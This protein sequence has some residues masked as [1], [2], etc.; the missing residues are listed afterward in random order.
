[1]TQRPRQGSLWRRTG[2]AFWL[3]VFGVLW[4]V[5]E[6]LATSLLPVDLTLLAAGLVGAFIGSSPLMLIPSTAR[7]AF[8]PQSPIGQP[9]RWQGQL[10]LL[11]V[12]ALMTAIA[13]ARVWPHHGWTGRGITE[14]G[15]LAALAA[16]AFA[17]EFRRAARL[18]ISR[19]WK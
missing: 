1:M 12:A 3:V 17:S 7:F 18:W 10:L 14:A 16:G 15:I 13:V 6:A 4:V 8:G 11:G 5:V 9:K 19:R 2:I